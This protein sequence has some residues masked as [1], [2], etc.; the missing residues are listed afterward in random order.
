MNRTLGVSLP[1]SSQ[2][3]YTSSVSGLAAAEGE[4]R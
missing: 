3:T 1:V 4:L 2:A